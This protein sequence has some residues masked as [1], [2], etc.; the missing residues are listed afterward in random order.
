VCRAVFYGMSSDPLFLVL[1]VIVSI[2]FLWT[3]TASLLDR[4][5]SP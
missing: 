4:K 1:I 2:G 3:L 5:S